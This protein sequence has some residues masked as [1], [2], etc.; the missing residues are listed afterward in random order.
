MTDNEYASGICCNGESQDPSASQEKSIC[1]MGIS[2]RVYHHLI[3]SDITTVEALLALDSLDILTK[4]RNFGN[5]SRMEIIEKMR[6]LG[7]TEWADRMD[8]K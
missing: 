3:L 4:R 1:D 7:H 6:L 2:V 8:V 5:I